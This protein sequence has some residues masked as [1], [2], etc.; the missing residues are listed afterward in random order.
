MH[1]VLLGFLYT[2]DQQIVWVIHNV[3]LLLIGSCLTVALFKFHQCSCVNDNFH[4]FL[5][6]LTSFSY[7]T[8]FDLLRYDIQYNICN[9]EEKILMVSFIFHVF[10]IT[11]IEP[12]EGTI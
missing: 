6:A 10:I 3:I 9:I 12:L 1:F 5:S 4:C 2:V 11:M 8:I 7:L